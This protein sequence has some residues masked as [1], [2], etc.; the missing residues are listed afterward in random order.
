[1]KILA[2]L[3]ALAFAAGAPAQT[4]VPSSE[5]EIG[6][7]FAPVVRS[8]VPSVV[9]IYA[10]RVVKAHVSP[11]ADDPFFSRFFGSIPT[12]P[13]LQNS[14][15]SGVILGRGGLVVSNF[16]VVGNATDIRVVLPDR[17]EFDAYVVLGDA[18]TDLA[19]LRLVDAPEMP[20]LE[21]ADSDV[22]EVGDLVLAIGNPFGVGQT[23]SSGIISANARS[24]LVSGRPGYFI[25]TDAPINPGNS[26]GALVDMAGRL[27]GI[28]TAIMTRSGG[29]HGIGFAIP[30]SLVRQYVVQAE[31][32]NSD[33][34]RP[35]AGIATQP[36]DG[37]LAEALGLEVPQGVLI[38]AMHRQSPFSVAGLQTGDV[39]IAIDGRAVDGEP[40]MLFRLLARGVGT[41][42][43][44]V[45]LRDAT[46]HRARVLLAPAPEVPPRN[47]FRIAAQTVLDGLSIA[48]VNPALIEEFGL[49]L[50]AEGVVV[51][52]I[53]E[54]PH[55]TRLRPGDVILSIN[56]TR[57]FDTADLRSIARSRASRLAIEFE[58]GG[59]RGI[60]RLRNGS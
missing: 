25:Q 43:D 49:P 20:A 33:L 4:R 47:S 16:H 1:M 40:E 30:A 46:E 15:G 41:S 39:V 3:L 10:R 2:V 58:R 38:R 13:R 9:N 50:D 59:Q 5:A 24:S 57:I 48:N 37:P 26:G 36:V 6:L 14:L 32:G 22:V 44:V 45:Y 60:I 53:E 34:V 17:R 28:N 19:V 56:G 35:W 51:I 27:V 18:E 23:V 31:A 29:S 12:R 52:A 8:V 54:L 42:A 21:F 7:S 11:I 55:R